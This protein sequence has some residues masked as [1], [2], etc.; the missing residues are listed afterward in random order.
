[1]NSSDSGFMRV[2]M[3]PNNV[4]PCIRSPLFVR[5]ICA[6]NRPIPTEMLYLIDG[7]SI[8]KIICLMPVRQMAMKRRPSIRTAVRANCQL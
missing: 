5:P 1:M 4:L 6:M 8:S 2:S 7:G 3:W